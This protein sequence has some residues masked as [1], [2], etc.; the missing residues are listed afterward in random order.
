MHKVKVWV[1]GSTDGRVVP[2]ALRVVF[3][4]DDVE[5]EGALVA[6][7]AIGAMVVEEEVTD[8]KSA[9]L[10]HAEAADGGEARGE[11]V[12][13]VGQGCR[14]P[15]QES[16]NHSPVDGMNEWARCSLE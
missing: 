7:D 9:Q 3:A 1:G 5:G 10:A 16:M 8:P 6:G 15:C 13:V 4:L 14:S 12:P 11:P 2:L